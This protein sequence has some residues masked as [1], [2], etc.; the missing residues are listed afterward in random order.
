MNTIHGYICITMDQIS[1]NW[2]AFLVVRQISLRFE[3]LLN[4]LSAMEETFSWKV[5]IKIFNIMK[6]FAKV[7]TNLVFPLY[8][9]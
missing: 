6:F 7:V 3:E 1:Q 9:L 2:E 8:I 5:Y 4:V